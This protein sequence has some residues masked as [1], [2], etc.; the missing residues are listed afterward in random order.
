MA[1]TQAWRAGRIRETYGRAPATGG[2]ERRRF[3]AGVRLWALL[4][5]PA[6]LSGTAGGPH[7]ATFI[8]DDH[9]RLAARQAR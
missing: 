7:D 9:S 1:E 6:L 4:R 8:E 2:G 5:A 3:R